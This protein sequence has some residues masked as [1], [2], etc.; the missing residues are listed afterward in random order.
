[1][2]TETPKTDVAGRLEAAFAA[3][4]MPTDLAVAIFAPHFAPLFAY[5]DKLVTTA[6]T[7]QGGLSRRTEEE[8][9]LRKEI[10]TARLVC[11]SF[12]RLFEGGALVALALDN[13]KILFT[14]HLDLFGT[15]DV[16]KMPAS[17]RGRLYALLY[18]NV[19]WNLI[20]YAELLARLQT[21][22]PT[23]PNTF[24]PAIASVFASLDR[25]LNY[26]WP[27]AEPQKVTRG[28]RLTWDRGLTALEKARIKARIENGSIKYV[29]NHMM[30][31]ITAAA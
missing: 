5:T 14:R 4:W 3:H 12:A 16:P 1:M 8:E 13:P 28:E 17:D 9:A 27:E 11:K 2:A 26:C 10:C 25:Q 15:C 18:N 30:A 21:Y 20:Y 6:M 22:R 19:C 29:C 7:A 31:Q 24:Y 23:H